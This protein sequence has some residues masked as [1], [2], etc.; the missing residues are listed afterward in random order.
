MRNDIAR[1]RAL[2][3][4]RRRRGAEVLRVDVHRCAA[5]RVR[6]SR[7][8]VYDRVHHRHRPYVDAFAFI[9][10]PG[11]SDGTSNSAQTTPDAAGKLFD[12]ACGTGNVDALQG[13]PDAGNWFQADFL[14][15]LHNAYPPLM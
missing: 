12:P 1:R 14:M 13:A 8:P 5:F 4:F 3:G 2:R 10:P 15:L 7:V 6:R 11:T 9:K